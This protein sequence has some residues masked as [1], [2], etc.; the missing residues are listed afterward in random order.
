MAT[1][2]LARVFDGY[3]R[4]SQA[5]TQLKDRAGEFRKQLTDLNASY[6]KDQELHRSLWEGA[7]DQALTEEQRAKRKKDA[8][9][10]SAEL[11]EIKTQMEQLD[12]TAR[13]ALDGQYRHARE[14]ILKEIQEAVAAKA[15]AAGYNVVLDS[16]S[17]LPDRGSSVLFCRGVPDLSQEILGQLNKNAPADFLNPPGPK[18]EHRSGNPGSSQ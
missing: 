1:L 2:D 13:A 9:A 6:Q 14:A 8:A 7:N 3:W 5:A 10:K 16:S 11:Q 12:Q 18:P 17:P 15:Q 4:T